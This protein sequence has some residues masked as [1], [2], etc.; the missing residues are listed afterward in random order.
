[1]TAESF[2]FDSFAGG[3]AGATMVIQ[4][5]DAHVFKIGGKV[6]AICDGVSCVVKATPLAYAMLLEQGTATQAPYL[7]RGGWIR[8][9]VGAMPDAEVEA[10]I[11]QSHQLIAA[12]LPKATRLGL[13]LSPPQS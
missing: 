11:T 7:T 5:G 3:S 4:W 12:S 8:I 10:L 2:R 1:M 9:A 6:F 13:G